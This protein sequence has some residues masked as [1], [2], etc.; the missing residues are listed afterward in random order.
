MFHGRIRHAS[1]EETKLEGR[2]VKATGWKEEVRKDDGK[3][4]ETGQIILAHHQEKK[5]KMKKKG[6]K[7]VPRPQGVV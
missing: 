2:I 4:D 1:D 6:G 3:T 5:K 7:V